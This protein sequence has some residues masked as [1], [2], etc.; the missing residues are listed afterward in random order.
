MSG[1]PTHNWDF[2]E[3]SDAV[4]EVM[5]KYRQVYLQITGPLQLPP[6]YA[7]F[8][9]RVRCVPFLPWRQCYQLYASLDI[10]L[11]PL[12][13]R[14]S[15]CQGKSEIKFMEAG[16][17]GVPTIASATD[18]YCHAISTGINGILATNHREWVAALESLVNNPAEIERMGRS[19][20]EYVSREYSPGRRSSD[21]LTELGKIMERFSTEPVTGKNILTDRTRVYRVDLGLPYGDSP[22]LR[23]LRLT[24][25]KSVV[26]FALR[27]AKHEGCWG[28][29]KRIVCYPVKKLKRM[30]GGV[31]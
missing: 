12:E 3:V 11:A 18:S 8:Q 14:E 5:R 29:L 17:V 4:V 26:T 9:R 21:L 6:V 16:M 20:Q 2:A 25:L 23:P 28:L 10:N 24:T 30:Q 7:E 27:I 15:F 1:G 22:R 13:I 19:A 31:E